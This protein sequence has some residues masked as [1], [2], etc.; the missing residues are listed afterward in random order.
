MERSLMCWDFSENSATPKLM[1]NI[2]I[3][4][5]TDGHSPTKTTLFEEVSSRVSARTSYMMKGSTLHGE[6]PSTPSSQTE[7]AELPDSYWTPE[8]KE[9]MWSRLFNWC[10]SFDWWQRLIQVIMILHVYISTVYNKDL[11]VLYKSQNWHIYI[12][13]HIHTYLR[14][15]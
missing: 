8:H 6:L 11:L 4:A 13:I 3:L 5:I 2:K 15:M 12:N 9:S 10:Y 7:T 14:F 1:K